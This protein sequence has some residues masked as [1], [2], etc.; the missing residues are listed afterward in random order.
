MPR[1]P[2]GTNEGTVP[3]VYL[4]LKKELMKRVMCAGNPVQN[5]SRIQGSRT[6]K[7]CSR[8]KGDHD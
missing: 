6:A 7:H 8:K 5:S 4:S 3:N 2:R 1:Q